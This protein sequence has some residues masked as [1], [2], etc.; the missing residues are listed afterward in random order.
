MSYNNH[1]E[2]RAQE[3]PVPEYRCFSE[4][5]FEVRDVLVLDLV[6][7]TLQLRDEFRKSLQPSPG[8]VYVRG[9]LEPV[10]IFNGINRY[11][12]KSNPS[13]QPDI[14]SF[15]DFIT[16]QEPVLN[17]DGQ[18]I[19]LNPAKLHFHYAKDCS[20]PYSA[21]YMAII[22]VWEQLRGLHA[23]AHPRT[24]LP[25]H[26]L[27]EDTWVLPER[28]I[29]NAIDAREELSFRPMVKLLLDWI[30]RDI[31]AVYTLRFSNTT[32]RVEKG[33]DF[34]VIEY[35]RNLFDAHDRERFEKFGW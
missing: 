15:E 21:I 1:D 33:N 32:L 8:G 25:E 17:Q 22:C 7:H 14:N 24:E 2:Q 19:C 6:Q 4:V 26:L 9:A 20:Y 27:R 29:V 30:G 13:T 3:S 31:F 5:M 23:H 11:Y 34:R 10:M 18:V 16:A 35:Y 28:H 12:T